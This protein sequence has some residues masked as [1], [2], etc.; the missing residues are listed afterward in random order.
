MGWWDVPADVSLSGE[1][2]IRIGRGISRSFGA[3]LVI[4]GGPTAGVLGWWLLGMGAM[5]SS[6]LVFLISGW[7]G[8]RLLGYGLP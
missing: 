3:A 1:R 4:V 7:I 2:G 8:P 6:A 5:E